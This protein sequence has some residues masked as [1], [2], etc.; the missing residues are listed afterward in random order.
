MYSTVSLTL[1]L[2]DDS[3]QGDQNEVGH[4]RPWQYHGFLSEDGDLALI[5]VPS[6]T[7]PH[8]FSCPTAP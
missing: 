3:H 4:L 8:H 7:F 1:T 2:L 6:G 5:W